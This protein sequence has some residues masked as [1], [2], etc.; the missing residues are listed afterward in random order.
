MAVTKPRGIL[1][2]WIVSLMA[3]FIFT[4]PFLNNA[5]AEDYIWEFEIDVELS[6]M[7]KKAELATV[8][9]TIYQGKKVIAEKEVQTSTVDKKKGRLEETVTV[10]FYADDIKKDGIPGLATK[11]V[12]RLISVG[13][14]H[15][16]G[17]GWNPIS[18]EGS[19]PDWAQAKKGSMLEV[20]D[21]MNQG[22]GILSEPTITNPD[23]KFDGKMPPQ[24]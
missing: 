23:F 16:S 1:N 14:D 15:K 11:Y 18:E 22:K 6:R 2:L 5:F 17:S 8:T 21:L 3:C 20:Y 10:R 12:A 13:W 19:G 4:I 9:L 7:M 24:L